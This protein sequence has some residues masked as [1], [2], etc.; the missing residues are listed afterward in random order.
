MLSS[1]AQS[2]EGIM[3]RF[4]KNNDSTDLLSFD[5]KGILE[6]LHQCNPKEECFFMITLNKGQ[7]N[8][9]RTRFMSYQET[10]ELVILALEKQKLRIPLPL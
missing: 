10:L 2:L 1:L 5:W 8:E 6:Q 3:L 9:Y 7:D 4:R